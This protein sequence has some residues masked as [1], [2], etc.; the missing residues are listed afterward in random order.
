M[1]I[2]TKN[3]KKVVESNRLSDEEVKKLREK[4]PKGTRI[5]LIHMSE[6][7]AQAVPAGTIGIVTNVDYIGTI[8]MAWETGSSLGLIPEVDEFEIVD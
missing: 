7:I 5:R 8:H 2:F 4:Y 6:E 1:R 3:N